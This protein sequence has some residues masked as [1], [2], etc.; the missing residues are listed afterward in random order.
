M[1]NSS[2]LGLAICVK[3]IAQLGGKIWLESTP[4]RRQYFL[5]VI[6]N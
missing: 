5:C 1:T 6:K 3:I 4:K 2:G